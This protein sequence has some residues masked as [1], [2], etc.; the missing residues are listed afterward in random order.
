M[1]PTEKLA[2]GLDNFRE[3]DERQSTSSGSRSAL[4]SDAQTAPT[5]NRSAFDA[6]LSMRKYFLLS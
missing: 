4:N 5:L 6:D 1:G 3:N 2:R